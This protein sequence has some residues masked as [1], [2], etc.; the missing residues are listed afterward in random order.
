[1]VLLIVNI[2]SSDKCLMMVDYVGSRKMKKDNLSKKFSAFWT[3]SNISIIKL[4]VKSI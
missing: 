2:S 4:A 1:M 3:N